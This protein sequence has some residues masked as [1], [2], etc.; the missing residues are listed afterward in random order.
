MVK[1]FLTVMMGLWSFAACAQQSSTPF[2]ELQ[3]AE[4]FTHSSPELPPA[5]ASWQSAK[6]PFVSTDLTAEQWQQATSTGH[7]WLRFTVSRPSSEP[8]LSILFWRYNLALTVYFNGIEIAA[9]GRRPGRTTTA[10]NRPLLANIA[11]NQWRSGPNEILVQLHVTE[12]GGNLAPPILGDKDTLQDMQERR[13]FQQVTLNQILLAFA[14]TMAA[15]TLGLWLIRRHDTIYLWFSC[16]CCTWAIG[17][18]QT[19][20][21]YNPIP[22]GLWLPIVHIAM[23][24]CIFFIYGFIGRLAGTYRPPLE[25]LFLG[26]T[27]LAALV[28]LLVPASMFWYSAYAM[29]LVGVTVLLSMIVRVILLAVREHKTEAIIVATTI[30]AQIALF[31]LNASQMFFNQNDGWDGTLVYSHFGIPVLLLIFAAVLLRRFTQALSISET[32][33]RELEQK[34]EVS[35]QIIARSFEERRKLE[36]RQAA[37]MERQKIYRDLHDDVGSRLL[38]IIHAN[39]DVKVGDLARSTLESLRQAVSR[40][41]TPD[42]NLTELMADIREESEL[43]LVGSGHTVRWEQTDSTPPYII[44]SAIAFNI[45]RIMKELVSNIIRHANANAV[46][47]T[48]D[49]SDDKLIITVNDDGRGLNN[50]HSQGNGLKNLRTR[51]A[52]IGAEIEWFSSTQGLRTR[53]LLPGIS[54]LM[55]KSTPASPAP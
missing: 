35:R 20:I 22:Y 23:D 21:Y 53:L 6:L 18:L 50:S 49:F 33:N 24:S 11:D 34:I 54:S 7:L 5:T 45:N 36:I 47:I 43:R 37:E 1:L 15:F 19:V 3:N 9:N 26:W 8:N 16:I 27:I 29:H 28:H 2:V 38:S 30:S 39:H 25:K 14:A 41:N 40:A 12:W 17:T 42:Q 51:A 32:L 44:P 48:T 55:G 52:E 31:L 46:H 13:L 10:W 4:L